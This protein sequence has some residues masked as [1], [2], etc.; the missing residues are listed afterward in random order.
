MT[1]SDISPH[2]RLS[3]AELTE[4]FEDSIGDI[5]ATLINNEHS[6]AFERQVDMGAMSIMRRVGYVN[7][8]KSVPFLLLSQNNR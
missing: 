1:G 7:Q 2:P 3:L 5:N 6:R 8:V 4:T